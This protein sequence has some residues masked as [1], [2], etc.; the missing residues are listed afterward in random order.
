MS[1][2]IGGPSSA[3]A[4]SWRIGGECDALLNTRKFSAACLVHPG[5]PPSPLLIT[6]TGGSGTTELSQKL[7][8]LGVHVA[9][10]RFASVT[11]SWQH[12]VND[13]FIRH[14][15]PGGACT[16]AHAPPR[17]SSLVSPRFRRVVHLVRCPLHAIGALS[18]H[19]CV[20][21]HTFVRNSTGLPLLPPSAIA[22]KRTPIQND[23][24]KMA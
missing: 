13:V 7:K 17:S 1:G 6:A 19:R 21:A 20:S 22:E 10:Q 12:A 18:T 8:D 16:S 15:Y 3:A 4:G 23:L 5:R 24:L 11:I 9:H 2:V 14:A